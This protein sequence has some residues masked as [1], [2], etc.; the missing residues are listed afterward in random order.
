MNTIFSKI[1]ITVLTI[2][3]ASASV[4][5]Q[6][7]NQIIAKNL[8]IT[9][10][11][12]SWNNLNS[13]ILKGEAMLNVDNSY[14]LIIKHQRPYAKR[15]TFIID[16]KEILNEGYDGTNGWTYSEIQKK[17]V[18]VPNYIPDAFDSDL[19]KYTQKGFHVKLIGKESYETG[20]Q[21]YK[22]EL[23]KN[24]NVSQY[25]FD[26]KT[27]HLIFEKNNDETLFYKD[28]KNFQGLTF[29]T[30]IIGKP[31]EG[32]EYIIKFSSIIINPHIDKKEFKF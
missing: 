4:S 13:I 18:I 8:E 24:K 17:N 12:K 32:G 26:D 14:P 16:G 5:A 7:V 31:K 9:G 29:A 30:K 20:K 3:L 25:C 21:C 22:I 19:L 23:T 1:K 11:E 2:L 27:Y 6:D 28:Y 10:G 15:V